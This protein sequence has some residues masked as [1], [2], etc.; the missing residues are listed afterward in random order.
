[1]KKNLGIAGMT[2]VIGLAALSLIRSNF[3][4]G[5]S[6]S[7]TDSPLKIS[8]SALPDVTYRRSNIPFNIIFENVSDHHVRILWNFDAQT[9]PI[10]FRFDLKSLDG[11]PVF[12]PGAGKISFYENSM[13]YVTLKKGE[14]REL[15]INLAELIPDSTQVK[16]GHYNVSVGYNNQYGTDC[17]K[18]S[19]TSNEVQL[20]LQNQ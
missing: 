8:L 10:F 14:K 4:S 1:M 2:L 16:E 6:V 20:Y 17:F 19:V 5:Q 7:T 15:Q 9:L 3:S 12:L 11:T 13:K 18:G